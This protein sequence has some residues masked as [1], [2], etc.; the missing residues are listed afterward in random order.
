MIHRSFVIASL[1]SALVVATMW[2]QS[3]TQTFL[4]R[5]KRY[6]GLKSIQGW[7]AE[8]PLTD[9]I[10]LSFVGR[11]GYFAANATC[12]NRAFVNS[13]EHFWS[14]FGGMRFSRRVAGPFRFYRISVPFWMLFA[15][16]FIYPV[17]SLIRGPLRRRRRRKRNQC[18]SCGYN[19]TGLPEPRCPE[20]G[21]DVE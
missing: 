15:A 13:D 1:M 6:S 5:S 10:K 17:L 18:I 9:S 2:W 20:C 3:T 4:S 16:G 11:Q 14:A 8:H 21:R 19:L 7:K 12:S